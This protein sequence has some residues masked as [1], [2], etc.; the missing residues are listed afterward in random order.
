MLN[1]LINLIGRLGLWSYL[2]ILLVV[3]LESQACLGL[4]MPGENC[5]PVSGFLAAHGL[6]LSMIFIFVVT[7]AAIIGYS[8]GF[9]NVR[10]FREK[11]SFVSVGHS[12]NNKPV[13][14]NNKRNTQRLP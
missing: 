4:L 1:Y 13:K 5:V 8:L 9:E 2:I 10:R 11:R 7:A 14:A 3:V 12:G 6:S